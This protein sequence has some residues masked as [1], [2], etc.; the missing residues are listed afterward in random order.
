MPNSLGGTR[1]ACA[2]LSQEIIDWPQPNL[3]FD[4]LVVGVGFESPRNLKQGVC[5]QAERADGSQNCEVGAFDF[6]VSTL[7]AK[8]GHQ[9]SG[10][11]T[12][13]PS[14]ARQPCLGGAGG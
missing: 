11:T 10:S 5:K 7:V 12:A 2:V 13:D 8:A 4:A 14:R 9:R 6:T 3:I 1:L